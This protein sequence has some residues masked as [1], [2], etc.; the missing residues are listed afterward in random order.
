MEEAE[1]VEAGDWKRRMGAKEEVV[2]DG[3]NEGMVV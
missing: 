2:E 1:E 3:G